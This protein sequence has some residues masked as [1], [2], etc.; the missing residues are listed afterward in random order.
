[1]KPAWARGH[2][3]VRI[4]NG[5]LAMRSVASGEVMHPGVGP[6]IEAETL[7]VQQSQV[8]ARLAEAGAPL[9]VFDVGLGAGSNAVATLAA[10]E[11]SPGGRR[12]HLVS[13]ER[14]LDAFTLALQQ[15]AAF[16][17][18][19]GATRAG[20]ALLA[21][22]EHEGPR[23]TW[24]LRTGDLTATLARETT[25]ADIVYW[26]PFSPRANPE[27]WTV[28]SFQLLRR[29]AGPGAV[30]YTYSASTAVRTAL[31]LAGWA[32]G[33]GDA[34]GTKRETT[35]A[36]IRHADLR[37]PLDA[38]FLARVDR[39]DAPWPADAP[40]DARAR[41]AAAAQFAT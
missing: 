9:V 30:L 7:Y 41:L 38:R 22:R 3:I 1:M 10:A 37:R 6:Q 26:D 11:R 8:A 36:A 20:Q 12:L 18:D 21:H 15:P 33:A 31:L 23:T 5:S 19:E 27:L 32:V 35:A 2:E 40:S 17:F 39:S 24:Q 25:R 16:G 34:I 14:D 4:G 29:C 28:A 13:F